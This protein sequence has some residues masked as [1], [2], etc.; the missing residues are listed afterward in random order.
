MKAA[1]RRMEG[2]RGEEH[3]VYIQAY[4]RLSPEQVH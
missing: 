3:D 2:E 4:V 1:N